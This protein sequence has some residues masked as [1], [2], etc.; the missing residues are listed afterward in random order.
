M[1]DNFLS[2][3][4]SLI[5]APIPK[6][7]STY[8][9]VS[10]EQLMELCLDGIY[11]AGFTVESEQYESRKGGQVAS[12][13]YLIKGVDDT[14]MQLQATWQNSYDKSI[15]LKFVVGAMV[16]V[17]SN[18]MISLRTMNEYRHKH[19]SDVQ[20]ISP[21]IIPERIKGAGE[22]FL[23]LQCDRELL[24]SIEVSKKAQAEVIGRL[25][26]DQ[27]FINT[28]QL[29]ILKK[30]LTDPHHDYKAPNSLWELYN[31]TTYSIGGFNPTWINDHVAA[32]AYFMELAETL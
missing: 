29:N 11:R 5:L 31:Y 30:E 21:L 20:E 12:G 8:K 13:K 22:I 27:T 25:F 2:S 1:K 3:K 14:E 18:G 24:K 28:A 6:Q 4:E 10:H 26:L 19:V 17:C 23:G 32:H 15:P 16:L 9:P 7:T